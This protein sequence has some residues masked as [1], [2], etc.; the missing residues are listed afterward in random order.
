M[1]ELQLR[2]RVGFRVH[3]ERG[4]E[5]I[6]PDEDPADARPALQR[7]RRAREGSGRSAALPRHADRHG[8]ADP[9]PPAGRARTA[10]GHALSARGCT[11]ARVRTTTEQLEPQLASARWRRSTSST[12]TSRCSRSRR[13]TA[14][15]AAAREAGYIER[16]V[17]TVGAAASTGASSRAAASAQS[18]FG[19]QQASSSCAFPSGKPGTEGSRAH[20]RFACRP[21]RP[22]HGHSGRAAAPRLARAESA[23]GSARSTRPAW[24]SKRGRST[25]DKLPAWLAARLERAGA[26]APTAKRSIPR[27]PRRR[28]PARR[29][30][31]SAEAGAAASAGRAVV[32]RRCARRC[33]TSR[34]STSYDSARR[35]SRATPARS[36]ACSRPAGR[37]RGAAARAVGAHRGDLRALGAS[38]R[39]SRAGVR[40]RE[41]DARE[42]ASGA[43][44]SSSS[45][46]MRRAARP[47]RSKRR[48]SHA[49]RI[50]R[51]IKGVG[52]ATCG[53]NCCSWGSRWA[54]TR[55]RGGARYARGVRHSGMDASSDVTA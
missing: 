19:A 36:R 5:L 50:D 11:A 43:A 4:R 32:R 10:A 28:Q 20:R 2:Y 44:R 17:L 8:A 34:A 37:R 33:S 54:Y 35:C 55:A 27:R 49:A 22:R 52:A 46:A 45:S 23:R 26:G 9:A 31:G 1:R 21:C 24:W 39:A 51:M 41:A 48:S 12:A 40:C 29:A 47:R 53:T 16:E 13:P 6:A 30:P 38:S 15:A 18:L 3:D 42:R 25:R 7:L 14:F